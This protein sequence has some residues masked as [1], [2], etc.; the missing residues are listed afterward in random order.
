MLEDFYLKPD[1]LILLILLL[2]PE[3]SLFRPLLPEMSIMAVYGHS[4]PA[5]DGC[6]HKMAEMAEMAEM[7][8]CP[9]KTRGKRSKIDEKDTFSSILTHFGTLPWSRNRSQPVRVGMLCTAPGVVRSWCTHGHTRVRTWYVPTGAPCTHIRDFPAGH[10]PGHSS[11]IH[12]KTGYQ[13]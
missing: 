3:M 6:I 2:L 8:E 5:R 7:P 11:D 13:A 10:P 4:R 1:G 9:L 12:D